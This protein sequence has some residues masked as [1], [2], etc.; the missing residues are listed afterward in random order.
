MPLPCALSL[1]VQC[2]GG[3]LV[4]GA[5]ATNAT[6][7]VGFIGNGLWVPGLVWAINTPQGTLTRLAQGPAGLF[8]ASAFV[9]YN[10]MR[11]SRWCPYKN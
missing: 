1:A 9:G 2:I 10:L 7:R 6:G 4:V 3:G 8:A 11:G 5:A